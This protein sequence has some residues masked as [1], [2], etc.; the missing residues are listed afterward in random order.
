MSRMI[1]AHRA[2]SLPSPFGWKPV[3]WK[4]HG[5]N[6][7]T[8]ALFNRQ[9]LQLHIKCIFQ[10]AYKCFTVLPQLAQNRVNPLTCEN[11]CSNILRLGFTSNVHS[12]HNFYI[13]HVR[14]VHT[15]GRTRELLSQTRTAQGAERHREQQQ[16]NTQT[17]QPKIGFMGKI[18][19]SYQ[20]HKQHLSSRKQ[21]NE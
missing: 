21:P 14:C 15:H 17:A 4:T 20:H 19:M 16:N 7:S 5:S 3:L 9:Q 18:S 10:G 13:M 6:R 12:G 11:I 1:L 2:Q 8:E